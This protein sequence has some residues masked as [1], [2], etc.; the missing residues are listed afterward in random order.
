MSVKVALERIKLDFRLKEI[1]M[2]LRGPATLLSHNAAITDIAR[3]ALALGFEESDYDQGSS[4]HLPKGEHAF[5]ELAFKRGARRQIRL[6]RANEP[7]SYWMTNADPADNDD[8]NAVKHELKL[9]FRGSS[10]EAITF[11]KQVARSAGENPVKLAVRWNSDAKPNRVTLHHFNPSS[12]TWD[13]I[14]FHI[15]SG[16]VF[17][18]G[19]SQFCLDG[20]TPPEYLQLDSAGLLIGGPKGLPAYLRSWLGLSEDVKAIRFDIPVLP[21]AF[22]LNHDFSH[23]LRLGSDLSVRTYTDIEVVDGQLN[24]NDQSPGRLIWTKAGTFR[25]PPAQAARLTEAHSEG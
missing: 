24:V 7:R 22:S 5:T 2:Y 20:C 1:E 13:G 11:K 18:R 4:V 17:L 15:E 10:E 21:R 16:N 14:A 9:T 6:G 3:G 12:T 8:F 23:L 19:D 25:K